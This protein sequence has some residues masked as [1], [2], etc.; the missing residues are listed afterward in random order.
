MKQYN[1]HASFTANS[2][3]RINC[4]PLDCHSVQPGSASVVGPFVQTCPEV[5]QTAQ[6]Q[7]QAD[8]TGLSH[9]LLLSATLAIACWQ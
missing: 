2:V 5:R 9:V 6:S 3:L 1:T 8:G 4:D 7:I